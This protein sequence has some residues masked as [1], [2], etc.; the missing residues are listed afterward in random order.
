HLCVVDELES[1]ATAHPEVDR[2]VMSTARRTW[3]EMA[4]DGVSES[5]VQYF[6]L[7][8]VE[9]TGHVADLEQALEQ[10]RAME[11]QRAELWREAAHDLRG[12]LGVVVNVTAGLGVKGVPE[13]S[14]EN[15]FR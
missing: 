8:Q 3:A 1:Y 12:N 7:Q 15:F 14:R 5:T 6:H 13:Q 2:I 10:L 9:A 4:S 11:R